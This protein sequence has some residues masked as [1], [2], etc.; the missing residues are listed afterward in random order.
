MA[1][2]VPARVDN[3]CDSCELRLAGPWPAHAR[4]RPI[5]RPARRPPRIVIRLWLFSTGCNH[6]DAVDS[7]CGQAVAVAAHGIH[8]GF[9]CCVV[10]HLIPARGSEAAFQFF[11]PIAPE[12]AATR[13]PVA[14]I[15]AEAAHPTRPPP[16]RTARWNATSTT[17][18][19]LP[20]TSTPI[21]VTFAALE[22]LSA[23]AAPTQEAGCFRSRCAPACMP[24]AQAGSAWCRHRLSP[25]PLR[26]AR[27]KNVQAGAG[28]HAELLRDRLQGHGFAATAQ[29]SQDGDRPRHRRHSAHAR[30]PC[31]QRFPQELASLIW[32][33][34]FYCGKHTLGVAPDRH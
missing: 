19:S 17:M 34:D 20:V 11:Y 3:S 33:S 10:G 6:D 21:A 9:P 26:P 4:R 5:A 32:L 16:K 30:A 28:H 8:V 12:N 2:W 18:C 27:E 14:L 1:A 7:G 23:R 25:T 24:R 22:S 29:Q 31:R 13:R 15:S